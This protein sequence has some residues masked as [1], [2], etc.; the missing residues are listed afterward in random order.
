MR[1][2]PV[3]CVYLD[4]GISQTVEQQHLS[5]PLWLQVAR[6]KPP[7]C[8][9]VIPGITRQ[10]H[11]LAN[12]QWDGICGKMKE[13]KTLATTRMTVFANGHALCREN[14]TR[15]SRCTGYNMISRCKKKK[16]R[17]KRTDTEKK[18]RHKSNSQS[19]KCESAKMKEKKKKD[20][21]AEDG[22]DPS[23][24][25]L[26]AQHAPAAPLCCL[27]AWMLSLPFCTRKHLS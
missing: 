17:K 12:V 15:F 8:T 6:D 10:L 21:I 27:H 19:R 25:G 2:R 11:H 18:N 23:T 16:E 3:T 4:Q 7:T 20:R 9:W 22:F 13:R 24:S 1:R 26:W 5:A 14:K